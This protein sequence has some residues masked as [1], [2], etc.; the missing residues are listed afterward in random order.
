MFGFVIR[1]VG[2]NEAL[3]ISGGGKA[4]RVVSGSSTIINPFFEKAETLS[5]EIMTLTVRTPNVYTQEGVAISVDGVAQVKVS[6][7]EAAIRT[8]ASQFLGKKTIE[9]G[10]IALQTLEGHQRAM[11]ATMSVEQIYKDRDA[12]AKQVREVASVDMARM[13]ME[14][15][16]FTI[17]DI[18]DEN[19]YLKAL[20]VRRT[21]Q[22]KR[23][24][25]IGQAE[26]EKE[27]SIREAEAR[28]ESEAARL[29]AE[30]QVAESQR[31]FELAETGYQKE[32]N[33]AKAASELAYKLEEAKLRQKI[34]E[35]ELR[36]E[37]IERQQQ[38]EIRQQEV[39]VREQELE[40]NVRKP[41]EAERFRVETEAKGRQAQRVAEAEAEA[42][43]TRLRGA[44]D[45]E[46]RAAAIR[47]EGEAEAEAIRAR[48]QAEAEAMRLKAEAWKEYGQA[49]LA[50]QL[51]Q[52]LPELARAIA[53][54][55]AKTE[56][57]VVI[58]NDGSGGGGTGAAR[59]TDDVTGVVAKL[60]ELIESMTGIDIVGT[61][62]NLPGVV[63]NRASDGGP[64]EARPAEG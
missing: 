45:A 40:A 35:E 19:G 20:G 64:G 60:P 23:D 11:M 49:A 44:A 53:E 8:A 59:V 5:L 6:R 16:S 18:S 37:F 51:M 31:D 61:I 22:V 1:K 55:L 39:K 27:S 33:T 56:K 46:A 14:I 58:S 42:Q 2:P 28:R 7:D 41:A 26:A 21:S 3:V 25:A 50:E 48:G 43:A 63:S 12:F 47:L 54:P 52:V 10:Q 34:R 30:R 13:G 36:V 4:P 15:I 17:R 57:I 62:K 32:I 29:L 24:A 9:V 38:I